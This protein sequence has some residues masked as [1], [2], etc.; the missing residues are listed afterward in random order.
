[1]EG[2][3]A[4]TFDLNRGPN[5]MQAVGLFARC[6]FLPP[7]YLDTFEEIFITRFITYGEHVF[8]SHPTAITSRYVAYKEAEEGNPAA[9]AKAEQEE[10]K[11]QDYL[12]L[13]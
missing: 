10:Q 1:M 11:R 13:G 2:K 3:Q 7:R 5:H 4:L 9:L 6:Q 8:G 12:R